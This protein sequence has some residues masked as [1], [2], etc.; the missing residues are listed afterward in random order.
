M[1]QIS[2][3]TR[4]MVAVEPADFRRGIDGLARQCR[5][6]LAADPFSGALFVFRNRRKTAVK[7][8]AY[9]GQGYWLCHKRLSTGRFRF[10]PEGDGEL[11]TTLQAHELM[12]LLRGGDPSTTRA[13][14]QW[15]PIAIDD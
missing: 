12:V 11:A 2:A 7:V 9:D 15:R 14:P 10:W 6:E 8:L 4:V 3:Q 5:E 1:I 13:S